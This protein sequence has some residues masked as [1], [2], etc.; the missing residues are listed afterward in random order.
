MSCP[1][2]AS[3]PTLR[4]ASACWCTPELPRK[5]KNY[6]DAMLSRRERA[7]EGPV[8]P[9]WSKTPLGPTR[10][11]A[12]VQ[13]SVIFRGGAWEFLRDLNSVKQGVGLCHG[14]GV[15]LSPRPGCTVEGLKMLSSRSWRWPQR[16]GR[17]WHASRSGTADCPGRPLGYRAWVSSRQE[18]SFFAT[19]PKAALTSPW[20]KAKTWMQPQHWLQ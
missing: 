16:S 14:L 9:F 7:S 3:C 1:K 17:L 15:I 10:R 2:T 13:A 20:P 6:P 5:S 4:G 12:G 19:G 18:S 11:A 8:C